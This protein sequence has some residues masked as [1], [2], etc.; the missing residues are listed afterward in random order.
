QSSRDRVEG[1][2]EAV[3]H[4]VREDLLDVGPHLAAQALS[5]PEEGVVFG[6]AA[7]VVEAED[8]AGEVRVVG[9][10]AAELVVRLPRS[11][12]PVDEILHLAATA[13]VAEDQVELPVGAEAK[14]AAVVV[15]A[16][17]AVGD[18]VLEGVQLDEIAIEREGGP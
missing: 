12:G 8:D 4:S 1:E 15:A 10:R 18:V 6:S 11:E 7:V 16:G 14:D 2:A 13:V 5:R 9:L 3:A 17:V